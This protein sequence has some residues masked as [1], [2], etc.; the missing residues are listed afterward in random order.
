[1]RVLVVVVVAA[2]L[3]LDAAA[4]RKPTPAERAAVTVA[5]LTQVPEIPSSR[6]T[7]VIRRVVVSTVRPGPR[8]NFTRFAAAFVVARDASLF[9]P[10]PRTALIGL[11]RNGYR[12]MVGYGPNRVV[13]RERQFFFGGRRAAILR[14]LGI[15]CPS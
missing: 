8:A 3:T 7:V 14:D 2:V 15:R 13:C 1:M 9:P 11:H 12:I 5:V 6:A 10:G 4:S